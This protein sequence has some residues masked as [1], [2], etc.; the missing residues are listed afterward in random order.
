MKTDVY[1]CVRSRE[2]IESALLAVFG[3]DSMESGSDKRRPGVMS[4]IPCP[5]FLPSGLQMGREMPC[6]PVCLPA[7]P[8]HSLPSSRTQ[9]LLSFSCLALFFCLASR[10]LPDFVE[11]L[12]ACS[13]INEASSAYSLWDGKKREREAEN[14]TERA[15][16]CLISQPLPFPFSQLIEF[17]PHRGDSRPLLYRATCCIVMCC[18]GPECMFYS[19]TLHFLLLGI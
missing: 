17:N 2:G 8:V 1:V 10:P 19:Y 3:Y 9:P 6:S 4:H 7:S 18:I 12:M 16:D 15:L 13:K 5:C 11:L 14:R